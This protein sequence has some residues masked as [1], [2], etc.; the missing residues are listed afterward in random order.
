MAL[1]VDVS[2]ASAVPSLRPSPLLLACVRLL[3]PVAAFPMPI[4]HG[5][6]WPWRAL[7]VRTFHG[8][9]KSLTSTTLMTDVTSETEHEYLRR[10]N[11]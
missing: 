11:H 5:W 3:T 9:A 6:P 8:F 10:C 4:L 1:A 7:T 2:S